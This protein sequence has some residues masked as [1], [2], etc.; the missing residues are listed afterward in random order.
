[1]RRRLSSRTT[2]LWSYVL[3]LLLVVGLS[4]ALLMCWLGKLRDNDGKPMSVEVLCVFTLM[5]ALTMVGL[6]RSLGFLKRVEVDDDALYISNYTTEVRIPL[7][8][9]TDVRE[10]GGPKGLTRVSIALRNPSALGESIEFLPRLSRCWAGMDPAIRE[11]QALCR[12]L[13][14]K[15]G[16]DPAMPFDPVEKIFEAGDNCVLRVGRDYVL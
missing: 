15:N 9:V 2:I 12:Q 13:S 3:P 8:Q 14:A 1:M 7:S 11:L 6:V 4:C 16:V 5:W 10:S